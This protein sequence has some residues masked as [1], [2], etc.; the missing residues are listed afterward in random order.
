MRLKQVFARLL[1][2]QSTASLPLRNSTLWMLQF[3]KS[4]HE[5]G[6]KLYDT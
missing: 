2:K 1:L 4:M 3:L 5:I 6:I